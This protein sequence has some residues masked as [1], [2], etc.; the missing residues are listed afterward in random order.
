MVITA[1]LLESVP[2]KRRGAPGASAWAV[3]AQT[4]MSVAG[5]QDGGLEHA[6]HP[7]VGDEPARSRRE[8]IAAEAIVGFADH[9]ITLVDLRGP[10]LRP[11]RCSSRE[12]S[13]TDAT[14]SIDSSPGGRV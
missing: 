11:R 7:H 9:G 10:G 4:G 6:R 5:A 13:A 1:T 14:K 2:V 3:E 12:S 8:P